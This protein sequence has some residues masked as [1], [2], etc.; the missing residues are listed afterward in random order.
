MFFISLFNPQ[1]Y[2]GN[3]GGFFLFLTNVGAPKHKLIEVDIR[4]NKPGKHIEII[5]PVSESI[6][7]T[8]QIFDG[9][10]RLIGKSFLIKLM[11]SQEN[12]NGHGVLESTFKYSGYLFLN[13]IEKAQVELFPFARKTRTSGDDIQ[14]T[15]GEVLIRSTLQKEYYSFSLSIAFIL[16]RFRPHTGRLNKNLSFWVSLTFFTQLSFPL[17]FSGIF[18]LSRVP[19]TYSP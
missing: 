5:V 13:Y 14:L 18:P 3:D 6:F 8:F 15:F 7:W 4:N 19:C 16:F 11:K 9:K 10:I 2:V 1:E 17:F 12:L